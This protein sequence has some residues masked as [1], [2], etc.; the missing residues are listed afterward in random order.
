ML[1]FRSWSLAY[2]DLVGDYGT[3]H[4]GGQRTGCWINTLPAN[5]LLLMPEASSSCQCAFPIQCTMVFKTKERNRVWGMYSVEGGVT[6][7]RELNINFGAPGDRRDAEGDLWLSWPRPQTT[8]LVLSL[9]AQ[10]DLAAGG[11][12]TRRN[13]ELTA[14]DAA[15]A[16][17]VYAS[18]VRGLSRCVI[19]LVGEAEGTA[20]YTVRLLAA[21]TDRAATPGAKPFSVR[22]Q[23]EPRIEAHDVLAAAGKHN[24]A[25][26]SE[27]TGIRVEDDLKVELVSGV[28]DAGPELLPVVCGLQIVRERVLQVGLAAP[29]FVI[30]NLD[31]AVEGEVRVGNFTEQEFKGTVQLTVPDQFSIEPARAPVTLASGTRATIPVKLALRTKG[32]PAT[33]PLL[34]RLMRSSGETEN[35]CETTIEYLGKRGRVVLNPVADASVNKGNPAR[36]NGH[37]A[38][39]PVDGGAGKFGDHSHNRAFLK[40][41]LAGVPGKPVSATF[42]IYVPAGGHTQ[43]ADSG[44]IRLVEGEWDENKI[45]HNNA[46]KPGPEIAKLGRVDKEVWTERQLDIDLAGR[47]TLSICLDPTSCDGATFVSREG[48]QKPELIVEYGIEE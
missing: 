43:S 7:I 40:F 3:A 35:E 13:P 18:A 32:K 44:V 36:N 25:S 41:S 46:P 38:T 4:F 12:Y 5:G 8:R 47:K 21:E 42:R 2:Y 31:A 34:C 15:D 16:P 6:P 9:K 22:I 14:V 17:W 10:F 39:F 30:S 20:L 24:T 19:P 33:Q 23:G 26:I 48:P 37:A 11:R 45:N 28:K 27:V 29:S 1:F